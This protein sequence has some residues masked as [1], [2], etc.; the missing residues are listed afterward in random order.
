MKSFRDYLSKRIQ[1]EH[2]N[3]KVYPAGMYQ[4]IS[5]EPPGLLLVFYSIS[6][7]LEPV[8]NLRIRKGVD[9]NQGGYYD[10]SNVQI[11]N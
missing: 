10:D 2:I 11:K 4:A 7:E 8:K 6:I 9:G 5:E 1:H 3:E